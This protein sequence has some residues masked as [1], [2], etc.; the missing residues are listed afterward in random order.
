M[1]SLEVLAP[2]PSL[3]PARKPPLGCNTITKK[4]D[5]EYN[6]Y[7]AEKPYPEASRG[8]LTYKYIHSLPK[9]HK[10]RAGS[11]VRPMAQMAWGR[12][13][14]QGEG[15]P[16][17]HARVDRNAAQTGAGHVPRRGKQAGRDWQCPWQHVP[18]RKYANA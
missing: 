8:A 15:L 4:N 12:A 16:Q 9:T 2:L 3:T 6:A 17:L 1:Q 5:W 13:H 7:V 18:T 10:W 14:A 11:A